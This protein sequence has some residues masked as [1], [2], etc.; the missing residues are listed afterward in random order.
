MISYNVCV[1]FTSNKHPHV[2]R[3]REGRSVFLSL[4][5][6]I[7]LVSFA[8]LN[9][10][11]SFNFARA[12]V[13]ARGRPP[14][15]IIIYIYFFYTQATRYFLVILVIDTPFLSSSFSHGPFHLD[16]REART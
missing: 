16:A 6:L 15:K 7:V 11:R 3:V 5:K 8:P 12:F 2:S 4:Q 14:L 1:F 9:L 10:A 13:R